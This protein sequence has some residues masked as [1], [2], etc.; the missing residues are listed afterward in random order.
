MVSYNWFYIHVLVGTQLISQSAMSFSQLMVQQIVSRR[1]RYLKRRY[2][3]GLLCFLIGVIF[4]NG[5]WCFVFPSTGLV[6]FAWLL[7]MCF[8][9]NQLS[10]CD[11]K[12]SMVQFVLSHGFDCL[13]RSELFVL[14]EYFPRIATSHILVS[15][16]FYLAEDT[17]TIQ[18]TT[19]HWRSTRGFSYFAG[20]FCLRIRL[21]L[22]L[23]KCFLMCENRPAV[24]M[25][26]LLLVI[27]VFSE[28]PKSLKIPYFGRVD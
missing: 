23:M 28:R 2:G 12:D 16:F 27:F 7:I 24:S 3:L 17:H 14:Q 20:A 15:F 6:A 26:E 1:C 22:E 18:D 5:L 9:S 13:V 8:G 25:V 10:W 19:C 4:I 11:T 21:F